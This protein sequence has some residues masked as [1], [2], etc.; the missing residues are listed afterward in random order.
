[1]VA[2]ATRAESINVELLQVSGLPVRIDSAAVNN[3]EHRADFDY[4]ISNLTDVSV[5]NFEVV[6]FIL[7]SKSQVT[8]RL[9]VCIDGV[10]E[11][12]AELCRYL[13]PETVIAPR[14][15][16]DVSVALNE[17]V[18]SSL[19]VIVAVREVRT[20]DG[21][22]H[23]SDV[24]MT[25]G[26]QSYLKGK[27]YDPLNIK[28]VNHIKLTEADKL[29]VIR[30]SLKTTIS[31]KEIP[32]YNLLKNK[33]NIVL[34]TDNIPFNT[35]LKLKGFGISLLSNDQI[36]S[37]ADLEGDFLL[38]RFGEIRANGNKIFVVLTNTW[39]IGKSSNKM[40]LSGGGIFLEYHKVK[41]NWIGRSVGG[42]IS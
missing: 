42:W 27:P 36:Q 2:A 26:L 22:W 1:L 37:K 39:T 6:I 17:L 3:L 12:E 8:K 21:I 24:Q 13:P 11:S 20:D 15:S 10:I 23:L 38:L 14:K 35:G 40:Y 19:R 7:N 32:D 18:D 41:N 29:A 28:K 16:E 5:W 25:R 30:Q 33:K 4:S 31:R 9:S 34:S